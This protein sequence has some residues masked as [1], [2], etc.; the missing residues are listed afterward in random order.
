[1]DYYEILGIDEHATQ[2]QIKASYRTLAKKYHPDVNDAPN[3]AAFFRLIQEAYETLSNPA[4][5]KEYDESNFNTTNAEYSDSEEDDDYIDENYNED[6][7]NSYGESYSEKLKHIEEMIHEGGKN[8]AAYQT[9]VKLRF[10]QHNLFVRLLLILVRIILA[11][12][13]PILKII[14]LI[15]KLMTQIS[16]ILSWIIIIGSA[17]CIGYIIIHDKFAY[18]GEAVFCAGV[19][20]TGVIA[21]WLPNILDWLSDNFEDRID[22]FEEFIFQL[23]IIFFKKVPEINA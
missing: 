18:K 17:I 19:F 12:L 2:E 22:Q 10:M 7:E 9:Y 11:P 5:R 4:Q 20:V 6:S 23:R 15:L 1:M 16:R 21:F 13:I 3:A 14:L 8:V